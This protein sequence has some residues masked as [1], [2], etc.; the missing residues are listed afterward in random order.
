[1]EC[2]LIRH[3]RPEVS[4]GICYGATDLSLGS[5][6][7]QD[8]KGLRDFFSDVSIDRVYSSPLTRCQHL[9]QDLFPLA[10]TELAELAEFD[11]GEWEGQT[12]DNIS[13]RELT[14]W[15]DDLVNYVVPGGESL[16]VFHQRVIRA[17]LHI[18][19]ETIDSVAVVCHAGTIRSIL[20]DFLNIPLQNSTLINLDYGAV[21]KLSFSGQVKKLDYINRV[22]AP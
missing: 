5:T 19:D 11:F 20:C 14:Y 9:A 2:Y 3:T 6:Y 13:R 18:N 22:T 21:S 10:S 15:S 1:M 4:A 16:R 7:P 12:W 8:L 17:W